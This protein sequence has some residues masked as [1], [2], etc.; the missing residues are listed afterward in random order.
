MEEKNFS[1]I[2]KIR[3]KKVINETVEEL[4][5]RTFGETT[6]MAVPLKS[7][8]TRV[9]ALRFQLV[10]NW[11]LCKWYQLFAPESENFIHCVN[12]LMAC[13]DNLKF[14]D[15]KRGIDKNKTL[16]RMLVLKLLK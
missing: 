13:I 8:K 15:I 11:C 14:L 6:E 5:K 4:L 7:Y 9:D 1:E 10:E 3:L 16:T 2:S 12:E